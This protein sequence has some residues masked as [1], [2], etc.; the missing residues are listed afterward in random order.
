MR[1][2]LRVPGGMAI[3]GLAA[4]AGALVF[5]TPVKPPPLPASANPYAAVDFGDL[6]A[7]RTYTARD[8]AAL[9]YRLY[10][11]GTSAT[12]VLIHGAWDDG[13]G[14]HLLAKALR[15]TGASVIVPEMRG[16]GRSGRK[17]D[18]D[19]IGQ[20]E[21][22][23]ADLVRATR[24]LHPN[25]SLSLTGFSLGGGFV[26]RVLAGPDEALFDRFIMVSPALPSDAP[27]NRPGGPISLTGPRAA[28]LRAL[29]RLGIGWLDGLPVVVFSGIANVPSLTTSYSFRLATDFGPP[30]DYLDAL[31]R[32]M[33]P[34][35]LLI[36]GND[37]LFYADRYAPLLRAVRPDLRI[38]VVPGVDHLGMVLTPQGIA[39]VRAAFAEMTAQPR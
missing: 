17:G 4:L 8:G 34:A 24:P 22:D 15:D 7:R 12:V 14:M 18:I 9:G 19:Y 32:S 31:R 30:P 39:A 27:T 35:A 29:T 25:A 13:R 3:L 11:G 10:E 21:D 28:V 5:D 1:K 36:G 20:L 16:H 38:V 23:L 33:K 6:P 26:L 2:W 37:E